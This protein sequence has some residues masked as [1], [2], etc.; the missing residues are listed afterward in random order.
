MRKI[1]KDL[2]SQRSGFV[3]SLFTPALSSMLLVLLT[4]AQPLE[5][6]TGC[7]TEQIDAAGVERIHATSKVYSI[8]MSHGM[9]LGK[10]SVWATA[11]T[12]LEESRK[13]SLDPMLVVAVINVESRFRHK[14]VS[15]EGA[16]GLMQIHPVAA[17]SLAEE[18]EI[19]DWKGIESLNNPVLNIKLGTFYLG[20]LKKRFRDLKLALSAYNLGPTEVQ[21]RLSEGE[22]IPF[23]YVRKVLFAHRLY[24]K[25]NRPTQITF[26]VSREKHGASL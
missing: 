19:R 16:R 24:E 2:H 21:K 9:D 20:Q 1:I 5:K 10:D 12:V 23:G 6:E 3:R 14:A 7:G 25:E 17:A 13:H 8:L 11:E 15:T 26:P 4:P 22:A 18:A